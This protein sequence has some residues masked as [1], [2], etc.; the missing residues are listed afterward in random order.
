MSDGSH[1]ELLGFS[2]QKLQELKTVLKS[3]PDTD[4]NIGEAIFNRTLAELLE[5]QPCAHLPIIHLVARTVEPRPIIHMEYFQF[6]LKGYLRQVGIIGID[7]IYGILHHLGIGLKY[8]HAQ[9]FVHRDLKPGNSTLPFTNTKG[10]ISVFISLRKCSCGECSGLKWPNCRAVIGDFGLSKPVVDKD[11]SS[12]QAGTRSYYAPELLLESQEY[13][14]KTD[15]WGLGCVLVELA[16]TA[17]RGPIFPSEKHIVQYKDGD[18][19]LDL[20][21]EDNPSLSYTDRT[22]LNS[23]LHSLLKSNPDE[24][25]SIDDFLLKL[26]GLMRERNNIHVQ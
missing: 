22:N 20:K 8:L 3:M 24:R 17:T 11:R 26:I 18:T 14:K 10:L 19:N 15:M 9:N 6:D 21:K 16:S 23:L 7:E 5:K 1:Q 2:G 12:N 13:S 25:L 4:Q